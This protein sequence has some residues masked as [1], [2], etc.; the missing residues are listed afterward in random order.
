MTLSGGSFGRRYQ[1]DFASEAWQV[2]KEMT[3]PVQLLWTR[4]DDMQHDF[5]RNILSSHGRRGGTGKAISRVVHRIVSTP[6]RRSSIAEEALK[7]PKH[8]A[9]GKWATPQCLPFTRA[10]FSFGLCSVRSVV[11]SARVAA[12]LS[13]PSTLSPWSASSTN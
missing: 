10:E 12:P 4:E 5:Y 2:A 1:W 13:P 11:A 3:Q 6:I 8:I 9:S 7:D